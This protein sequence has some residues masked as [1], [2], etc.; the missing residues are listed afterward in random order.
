MGVCCCCCFGFL[1]IIVLIPC[2]KLEPPSL[3]KVTAAARAALP[4][5]TSEFRVCSCVRNPPKSDMDY[6]IFNKRTL[7][8]L[9]VRVHTGVGHRQI[10]RQADG[11]T[12]GK[13]DGRTSRQAGG[14]AGRQALSVCL[15]VYLCLCLS[16][17]LSVCLPPPLSLSS[18]PPLSLFLSK[19]A[20]LIVPES[21][22]S[23]PR[24]GYVI[25]FCFSSEK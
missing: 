3:V 12:N 5:P 16:V 8:F 2:G 10:D 7:S 20:F 19:A 4:S 15:S 21:S 13:T 24:L 9:C 17:C 18:P 6:K 25:S 11:R 14:Q 22:F 1:L 23:D